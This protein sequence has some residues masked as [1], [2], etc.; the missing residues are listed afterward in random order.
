MAG[1]VRHGSR[2]SCEFSDIIQVAVK[3]LT[4][5]E[6]FTVEGGCTVKQLKECVA[7]RLGT[8]TERLMLIHSGRIL[9]ES[10]PLSRYKG[11][12]GAVGL[13][14]VLRPQRTSAPP[15]SGI[16]SETVQLAETTSALDSDPD[17]LTP[18]PTSPLSLV[19][20]LGSLGLTSAGPGFLPTLQRQMERQLLADPEL[21]CRVLGSPLVQS[22]FSTSSPQLTRQ[23]ILSNPQTLQLLQTNPEVADMLNNPDVIT[24]MLELAHNPDMIQEVMSNQDRA[25]GNLQPAEHNPESNSGNGFQK[26]NVKTQIRGNPLVTSSSGKSQ[27]IRRGM[28]E[29]APLSSLFTEPPTNLRDTPIADPTP[30]NPDTGGMQSLLEQ[31]TACP[32]LMENLLSGPYVSSLLGSLM[33]NPD[34]AAQMLLSHPLFSGN[35]QLQQQMRQQLPL[36]LQ[37]MQSPEL[38]SAMLN[39]R[40]MEALLEIQQGLQTLASEAPAFIPGAGLGCFGT[41]VN[42]TPELLS[43][44]NLNNQSGNGPQ[45]ATVTE[46]QQQFVQQMLQTLAN[47]N[48]QSEE[49][50]EEL[51]QLNSMGFR[52]RQA[53]LQ[54]LIRTRGD[55]TAAIEYLLNSY[56]H[57]HTH[58]QL[59]ALI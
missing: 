1:A 10:E 23:L 56:I 57:T 41:S 39:P 14:M 35:P 13:C 37:Q 44:S 58:T 16:S 50:S 54:A 55:L 59:N 11:Q 6:D 21:M 19:E 52:D 49:E 3:T 42:P 36:F 51:D 22:S 8:P 30:Q 32:D 24:Q 17:T 18:S 28:E 25:L 40:A 33:Q 45:V 7:E 34:L 46:Q 5:R 26:T 38:L 20:G 48:N 2:A 43:D 31:I 29:T 4:E 27:P 53:N 9:S 47:T 12:D 15:T